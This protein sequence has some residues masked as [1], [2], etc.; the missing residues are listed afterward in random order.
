MIYY[1]LG[2]VV[3][4]LRYRA[5]ISQEELADGICAPSTISRIERGEQMP[6]SQIL[7]KIFSKFDMRADFFVGFGSTRELEHENS[8]AYLLEQAMHQT[9]T[10]KDYVLQLYDYV[11]AVDLQRKNI[12]NDRV[13]NLLIKALAYSL[14][15]EEIYTTHCRRAYSYLELHILNSMAVEFYK[16]KQYNTSC[17]LFE[18]IYRY[19]RNKYQ[20]A[21]VKKHLYP[22][23]LN[24]LA[25]MAYE[26]NKLSKALGFCR[27][28]VQA[29]IHSGHFQLLP[30]LYGNTCII[31]EKLG[32]HV[33][34]DAA[35]HKQQFFIS[36]IAEHKVEPMLFDELEKPYL[37]TKVW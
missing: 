33:E 10:E 16:L 35:Y 27:E 5:E 20:D 34:A 12:G 18:K 22:V 11:L 1:L 3:A 25:I 7:E 23:V 9:G 8:W 29:C 4:E 21:S 15:L 37:I 19:M 24:N 30:H 14:P 17:N 32:K 2:D 26:D 13:F 31:Y 6:S 28:G 36:L